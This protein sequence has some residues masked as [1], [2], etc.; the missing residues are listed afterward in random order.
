MFRDA[1]RALGRVSGLNRL[2]KLL[3]R[4][5]VCS[6]GYSGSVLR[7]WVGSPLILARS[8]DIQSGLFDVRF[9]PK[10]SLLGAGLR[11]REAAPHTVGLGR[12][13]AVQTPVGTPACAG[14]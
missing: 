10:Q 8:C 12:L 1:R 11:R 4:T 2:R 14:R 5:A 3:L 9:W 7:R 6:C 13:Y